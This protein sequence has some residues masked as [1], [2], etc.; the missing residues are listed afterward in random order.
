MNFNQQKPFPILQAVN[1]S[2]SYPSPTKQS[3]V[4][5]NISLDIKNK[6][7]YGII[8]LSGAG[9][10]TLL[11]S[12][13]GLIHPDKG[14]ILFEGSDI[15]KMDKKSF[16]SFRK[17]LGMVFQN[18]NLFNSRTVSENIAYP[19]EISYLGKSTI[20]SR[21]KELVDLV[22]LTDKA[23][24][25]PAHLSGG[26]KQR[27][28]IARALA[29]HP[30]ILL[31]DEA[32]SALDPK[33][34]QDI[35]NLLKTIHESLGI[36]I[37]L[38]THEMQV[39]KQICNKIAVIEKGEIIEQGAMIDL[40]LD[41]QHPL[42]K[43]IVSQAKPPSSLELLCFKK[44]N[45]YFFRLIFKEKT[46]HEPLISEMIRNIDVSIN[47]ISGWID[48][49]Q[50][51]RMGTLIIAIQSSPEKLQTALEYLTQKSIQYERLTV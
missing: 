1:I 13:A 24:Y 16:Q 23:H 30:K 11:R 38:I 26:E 29:N 41:P 8:G 22:H 17:K 48:H 37:I 47:I 21:V 9:K 19:L 36:T 51:L 6:D 15:H 3:P 10:S 34:T 14:Q 25:Y 33:T 43:N 40:F 32:T 39:V 49:I 42:T 4:L 20:M 18:F 27:V 44:E 7:I 5:Q 35:L 46:F 31:C 2:K 50:G 45:T 28:G 12:F